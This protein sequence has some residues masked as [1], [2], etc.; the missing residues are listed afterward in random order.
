L[1]AL[2]RRQTGE[3]KPPNG[4]NWSR[5]EQMP[6]AHRSQMETL[7]ESV[8]AGQAGADSGNLQHGL[9]RAS[10]SLAQRVVNQAFSLGSP[11]INAEWV[12]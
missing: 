10:V 2:P 5:K 4:L 1:A 6:I 12:V 7:P 8:P 9:L 11:A 3:A